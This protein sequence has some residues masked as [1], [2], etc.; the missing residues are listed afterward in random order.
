MNKIN[1]D[2]GVYDIVFQIPQIMYSTIISIIINMILKRLSLSERN[3]L[4]IKSESNYLFAQ[5]KSKN[6]RMCIKIK[7]T[8]F[9]F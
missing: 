4:A 3:I 2:N 1:E 5:N 9:L 8:I 7:L 6:I